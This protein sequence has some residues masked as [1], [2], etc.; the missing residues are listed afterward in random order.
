M[1]TYYLIY[2]DT[3]NVCRTSIDHIRK[4]DRMGLVA[5]RPLSEP[6][7]PEHLELPPKEDLEQQMHLISDSGEVW[8]GS[9]A[10]SKLATLFPRTKTWGILLK[11]P[12]IRH[13]ARPVYRLIAANRQSLG[14]LLDD[15]HGR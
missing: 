12:V 14:K 3:C 2:D 15:R 13:L 10:V 8:R 7:L 6:R 9:D 4:L 1:S 5:V 11:L